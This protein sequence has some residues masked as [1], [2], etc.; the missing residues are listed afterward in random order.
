MHHDTTIAVL[1]TFVINYVDKLG[2]DVTRVARCQNF[3]VK[4]Q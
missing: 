4:R 2:V 1:L 3:N